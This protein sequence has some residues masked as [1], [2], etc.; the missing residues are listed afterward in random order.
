MKVLNLI[1]CLL[2]VGVGVR[3]GWFAVR[4]GIIGRCIRD[5]RTGEP[6]RGRA[7]VVLGLLLWIASL[8]PLLG[9]LAGLRATIG[10]LI[11]K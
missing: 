7:A 4:A 5:P 1:M 3:M 9:G 11:G 8:I 6:V 2:A 10:E